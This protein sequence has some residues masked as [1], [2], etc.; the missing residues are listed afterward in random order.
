[1]KKPKIGIIL[2]HKEGSE[3][4][5]SRRAHYA[6]RANYIDSISKQN[7][8]V[9]LIPYDHNAIDDYIA[10]L[11]G[12]MIVGGAFDVD[13][14]RYG[15]EFFHPK[16]HLNK[17]RENFE[18]EFAKKF[19]ATKKPLLG[20]CNG[21]QLINIINGGDIIQ[22]IPDEKG[23]FLNHEQSKVKGKEDSFKA[24]HQVFLEENSKLYKIIAQKEIGTNSSHHQ[25]VKNVGKGLKINAYAS[26]GTIE[27]LE[28][29]SHPFCIGVQWHPEF[30]V[31][32]ADDKIF[33]A[34]IMACK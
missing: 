13:P 11:D 10:M 1:M 33:A 16:T 24:Y 14:T 28:D 25:A 9:I 21:M 15:E 22:H 30:A 26:D 32:D 2:D 34:F 19:L 23:E 18:F 8:L 7:A 29:E 4:G 3:E 12:L 17:I 6:I 5:Y 27:G 20:I 31:S